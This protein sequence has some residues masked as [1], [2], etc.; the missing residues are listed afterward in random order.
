MY[1]RICVVALVSI[2]LLPYAPLQNILAQPGPDEFITYEKESAFIRE[3]PV[4][5]E[6]RGL[7]GIA[8]DRDGDVWFYHSTNKTSTLTMFDPNAT[9]FTEYEVSGET[10][11]DEAIINLASAQLVFDERRGAVWFTDARIN[12]IGMLDV[13]KGETS[14]WAIP[15]P[16]AG[17]MGIALSP[18]GREVWFA[19]IM[20]N[21]IARF[22]IESG[23]ITEYSTGSNSGPALL[24][25]DDRGQLWVSLS[26]SNSILRVQPWAIAPGSSLGTTKF[27][28]PE[29][30]QFS[31]FGIAI[32]GGRVFLSDHGSSR[33]LVADENSGL[34]DY[35]LYWTSPSSVY[36]TT[37]PSQIV[38]DSLG[39]IYFAQ[40][41]GNR[42]SEIAPK[43]IM[44][45][46][47]VPTGPLSTVVFLSAS[48]EG[49]V[50]FAEWA[51]NKIGYLDTAQGLPFTLQVHDDVLTL[52]GA[53][54][55]ALDITVSPVGQ[56]WPL[57]APQIEI[58]LMGMSEKG[59]AGIIYEAQPPR[60]DLQARS[61]ESRIEIS[62][63]DDARPGD[64]TIMA[65][66]SAPENDGLAVSALFPI[67]ITLDVPEPAVQEQQLDSSEDWNDVSKYMAVAAIAGIVG[68]M[69]Y[70]R[71]R[72]RRNR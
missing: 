31:P 19:E 63:A 29:P 15:T 66:A 18:D 72:N 32:A 20:G 51:S 1:Y 13:Q 59:L 28:L 53:G 70:R 47:E 64:Y 8:T 23:D 44:I 33:I 7:R 56:D 12:S 52:D 24:T 40:H 21:K 22:D 27:S 38:T 35:E 60:I 14:L 37:L 16:M 10:A 3:F 4:P 67:K 71:V 61:V 62:A 26:F 49:G 39:N 5:F 9:E 30:E 69:V 41:G 17:P 34:Q 58:G 43:G 25:F 55:Q 54:K 46:Y 11:A 6:E 68:F 36:P 50:W 48:D 42:I 45:E 2:A 57:P 65:R